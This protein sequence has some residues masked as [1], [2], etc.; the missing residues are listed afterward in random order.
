LTL[1]NTNSE[2]V[3]IVTTSNSTE[4][5]N[6]AA[7]WNIPYIYPKDV[8]DDF[9]YDW[10]KNRDAD[11]F[12]VIS[13]KKLNDRLLALP[14]LFAF[15][16]HASLL[17]MLRGAAP[18]NWAIRYGFKETGTTS[19]VMSSHIDCGDIICNSP[20][21]ISDDETYGTLFSKLC[22]SCVNTVSV[23][24]RLANE[25]AWGVLIDAIH[26]VE[27]PRLTTGAYAPKINQSYWEYIDVNQLERLARSVY[28]NEGI[29]FEFT[30]TS[31]Y[32][33]AQHL[34]EKLRCKI[35]KL[36]EISKEEYY[37]K[38]YDKFQI[39]ENVGE[40]LYTDGKK[41]LRFKIKNDA[42]S[43]PTFYE[44]DE[45]QMSGKKRMPIAAFVK[46]FKYFNK[47]LTKL[48]IKKLDLLEI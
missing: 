6:L 37:G 32:A 48:Y 33:S 28:P 47:N 34:S 42:L 18:I 17:P 14:N 46:G 19:I 39:K 15:N 22:V 25:R 4:V 8:N 36:H 16:I 9:T 5:I 20:V 13:F 24:I 45:I 1:N 30:M 3:G 23:T 41:Y 7:K 27:L 12:C 26:Q 2:I 40:N 21:K 43:Y 11:L 29:P 31:I 38:E 44:V 10:L 35:Y